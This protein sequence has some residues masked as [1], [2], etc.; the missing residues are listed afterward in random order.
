AIC[1][2]WVAVNLA[3]R[4]FIASGELPESVLQRQ[5]A[6]VSVGIVEGVAL[7]DLPYHEDSTAE[8]DL[9][10]VMTAVGDLIEVQGTAERAPFPRAQLDSLLDLAASG[11]Q[12]LAAK[13]REALTPV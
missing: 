5:V 13:Q 8:V 6:A 7:L 11:I 1:G 4:P 2:G 9:N 12:T 3:L 10:V